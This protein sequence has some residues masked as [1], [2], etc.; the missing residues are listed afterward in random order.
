MDPFEGQQLPA[1]SVDWESD[2]WIRHFEALPA[3]GRL[4]CYV[5]DFASPP[6]VRGDS[7]GFVDHEGRLQMVA[8]TPCPECY[9]PTTVVFRRWNAESPEQ[10]NDLINARMEAINWHALHPARKRRA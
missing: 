4:S 8:E 9:R 3:D 6:R 10:R 1:E 5:F 7:S 2:D